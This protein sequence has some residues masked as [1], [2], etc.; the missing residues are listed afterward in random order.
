MALLL[1]CLLFLFLWD[2]WGLLALLQHAARSVVHPWR[3]FS[4]LSSERQFPTHQFVFRSLTSIQPTPFATATAII[5]S[6]MNAI[7]FNAIPLSATEKIQKR[8]C[9][10]NTMFFSLNLSRYKNREV[11]RYTFYYQLYLSCFYC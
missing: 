9:Y 11:C 10:N 6:T 2:N 4:W 7:L 1:R 8:T 3:H 5:T